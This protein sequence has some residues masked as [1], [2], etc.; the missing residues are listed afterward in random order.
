MQTTLKDENMIHLELMLAGQPVEGDIQT[1]RG[2]VELN[3]L[4]TWRIALTSVRP[5][6]CINQLACLWIRVDSE[7]LTFTV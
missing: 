2:A 6:L 1:V 5:I 7:E 4:E 3:E